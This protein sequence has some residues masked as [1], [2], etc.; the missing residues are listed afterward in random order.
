MLRLFFIPL[1]LALILV[2]GGIYW[3]YG[4]SPTVRDVRAAVPV[5]H[6]TLANGLT[7]VVMP[8]G[9]IPAVTHL[10]LV[11]AGCA[12]DAYGKSGMAHYLEHL[13]FTGTEQFPEGVYDRSIARVGGT[14][15]AY[16]TRDYTLYFATVAKEHLPMVMAMEADRLQH[17]DFDATHA[18]RELKVIREERNMRVDNNAAAQLNEQLDALTFLNHPYHHSTIGWAED[19][20]TF[21]AADAKQFFTEHY[22][23]SNMVLVVAGDVKTRDVR[24]YAQHYYG[25]LSG[26]AT[27]P[28][29]WPHEPVLHL[30][31]HAQMRDVKAHEAR[32]VRQY[33]APSVHEG[34]RRHTMPLEILA[35]Y[36]GGGATSVLYQKLVR[37]QKLATA[38]EADYSALSMGP[39]LLKITAIP[40]NDV[41]LAQLEQALD[42]E[43]S[44]IA[45]S[46]PDAAGVDRAKT[47]LKAEVIFAQDG[48]SPLAH[49]ISQLY[50]IGL[51]EQYFYDWTA[52]VDRVSATELQAAA[53]AV[54]SPTN[55]VTGYLMPATAPP[56]AST[57]AP[58]A[59]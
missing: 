35:H 51:D 33:V 24:R 30:E 22:R 55:R 46:A 52:A 13:M 45:S 49:F 23:A 2:A 9:R 32:L 34:D 40:A 43:L 54:L 29:N 14:Q 27:A 48:I 28:R 1:L 47:L 37:E 8:N 4:R 25:G 57:E 42:R 38:I 26:G 31:R 11:K 15:N 58:H 16:T 5:E 41:T 59:P 3:F 39:A 6:F 53:S 10:L 18:A 50:A 36:M 21:T 19:M 20:A 12:D 7:V 44:A 56:P 17:L